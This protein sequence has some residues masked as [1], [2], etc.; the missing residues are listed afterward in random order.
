VIQAYCDWLAASDKTT[1]W[2]DSLQTH[3]KLKNQAI[4]RLK[5]DVSP[6]SDLVLV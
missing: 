3:Q 4:N 6:Q 1:S 5:I 2:Q